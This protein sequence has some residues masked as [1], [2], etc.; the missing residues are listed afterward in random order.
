LTTAC[1]VVNEWYGIN[2]RC[3][4]VKTMPPSPSGPLPTA[5]QQAITDWVSAGH[6][7]TD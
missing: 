4:E 3:V 6:K 1:N 5:E 7:Y 2:Y